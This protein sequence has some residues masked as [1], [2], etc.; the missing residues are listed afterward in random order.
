M[1]VFFPKAIMKIL[2]IK[3]IRMDSLVVWS[4]ISVFI[5]V[6]KFK[7]SRLDHDIDYNYDIDI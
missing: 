3:M 5:F 1:A 7:S 2:K 4:H 6:E